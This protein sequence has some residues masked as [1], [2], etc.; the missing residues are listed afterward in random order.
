MTDA[1]TERPS[2]AARRYLTLA[3]AAEYSTLS[4]QTLRRAIRRQQLKAFKPARR[5]LIDPAE[6]DRWVRRAVGGGA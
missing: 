4:I 1:Q 6:L 2:T 5:V 3:E